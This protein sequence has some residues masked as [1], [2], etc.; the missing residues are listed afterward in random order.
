MSVTST[1]WS[2]VTAVATGS[3]VFV[4][5]VLSVAAIFAAT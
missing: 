2:E 4:T 5:A 3:L 1:D